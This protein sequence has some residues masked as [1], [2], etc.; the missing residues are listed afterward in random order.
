MYVDGTT[1]ESFFEIKHANWRQLLEY[2]TLDRDP[3]LKKLCFF[4]A[5]AVFQR[6][7]EGVVCHIMFSI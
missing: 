5:Q 6:F 7:T 1:C 2:S 3:F 4:L